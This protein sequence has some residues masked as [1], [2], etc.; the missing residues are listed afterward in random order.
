MAIITKAVDQIWR[1]MNVRITTNIGNSSKNIVIRNTVQNSR[2][3]DI[4]S[5]I[6]QDHGKNVIRPNTA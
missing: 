2:K 4:G 1:K 3:S 5:N 6:I